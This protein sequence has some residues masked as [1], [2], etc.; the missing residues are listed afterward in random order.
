MKRR[1]L[2]ACLSLT[3]AACATTRPQPESVTKPA[4]DVA[5]AVAPPSEAPKPGDPIVTI[6]DRG[7]DPRTLLRYR[8]VPGTT[9]TISNET[10]MT[11]VMATGG[12]PPVEIKMPAM[13]FEQEMS[14]SAAAAPGEVQLTS[15]VTNARSLGG[16][17]SLPTTVAAVDKMLVGMIGFKIE[18]VLTSRGR[19]RSVKIDVPPGVSPQAAQMG[20]I[21]ESAIRQSVA[22]WPDE[23]V[24]LG[25]KWQVKTEIGLGGMKLEQ[26]S[27]FTLESLKGDAVAL[28]VNVSQKADP[29]ELHLSAGQLPSDTK[30]LLESH[31]AEGSGRYAI[32]LTG[33][34]LSATAGMQSKTKSAL[35]KGAQRTPINSEIHLDMAIKPR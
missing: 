9:S 29:Q 18:A 17:E 33:R 13:I 24:G 20:P 11:M 5:Q 6:V 32:D 7:S 10:K 31:S 35:V 2:T 28:K 19:F 22:A 27:S 34:L 4:V 23:T 16:S 25:A 21:L 30:V 12:Q 3:V 14:W 8:I 26:I 15:R 1:R